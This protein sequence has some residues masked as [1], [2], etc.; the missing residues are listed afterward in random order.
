MLR[1]EA[2]P[3]TILTLYQKFE[4]YQEK[5]PSEIWIEDLYTIQDAFPGQ[6]GAVIKTALFRNREIPLQVAPFCLWLHLIA[7]TKKFEM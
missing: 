3:I 5:V 6:R 2:K 4:A 7:V 1:S